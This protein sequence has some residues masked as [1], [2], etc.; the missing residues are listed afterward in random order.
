MTIPPSEFIIDWTTP[1]E[2]DNP[3][4]LKEIREV[5]GIIHER[6]QK[7]KPGEVIAIRA[8]T[9]VAEAVM[10]GINENG[11][12]YAAVDIG[13]DPDFVPEKGGYQSYLYVAQNEAIMRDYIDTY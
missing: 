10:K 12:A 6:V 5:L 8:R 2:I 1:C 3:P 11:T 13:S 9:P 7:T 4:T